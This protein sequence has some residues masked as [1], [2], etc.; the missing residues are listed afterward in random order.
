MTMP[1][2]RWGDPGAR[3]DDDWESL[4]R[5]PGRVAGT[6]MRLRAHAA[7]VGARP[8]LLADHK[9]ELAANALQKAR[10]EVDR[11]EAAAQAARA[12]I[13][14]RAGPTSLDGELAT[15]WPRLV[16]AIEHARA[17]I[18]GLGVMTVLPDWQP[19]QVLA[20][21]TPDPNSELSV[22]ARG[23]NGSPAA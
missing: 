12:R 2:E 8:G 23:G 5:T 10:Q 21:P 17:E 18:Q 6:L 19:G 9:R 22:A 3:H 11:L 1:F 7:D 4:R 20:I 13:E 16:L 14:R 15:G